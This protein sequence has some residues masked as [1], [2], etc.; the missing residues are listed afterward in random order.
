MHLYNRIHYFNS[1][2]VLLIVEPHVGEYDTIK[3]VVI[4]SC[5]RYNAYNV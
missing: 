5:K 1:Y 3:G 2:K 4:F